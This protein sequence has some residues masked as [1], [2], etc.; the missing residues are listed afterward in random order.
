MFNYHSTLLKHKIKF[1]FK[2]N[3]THDHL[4]VAGAQLVQALVSLNHRLLILNCH[5]L[6]GSVTQKTGEF[7]MHRYIYIKFILLKCLV[8]QKIKNGITHKTLGI[9]IIF[10]QFL[11]ICSQTSPLYDGHFVWSQQTVYIITIIF[12]ISAKTLCSGNG[13]QN[14]SRLSKKTPFLL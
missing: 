12:Y 9:K 13:N 2:S 11:I 5:S 3:E 4:F 6:R 7:L 1:L 14:S 10:S 8:C